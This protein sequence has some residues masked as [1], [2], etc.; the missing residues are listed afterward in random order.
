MIQSTHIE[1]DVH[2]TQTEKKNI[3]EKRIKSFGQK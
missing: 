2:Q 1:N 3:V